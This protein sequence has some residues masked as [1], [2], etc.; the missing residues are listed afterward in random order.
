MIIGIFLNVIIV[1]LLRTFFSHGLSSH[2]RI[3]VKF[4]VMSKISLKHKK[5]L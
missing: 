4:N 5:Y 2:I 1:D 3:V